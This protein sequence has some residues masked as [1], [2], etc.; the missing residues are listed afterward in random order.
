[1]LK[2]TNISQ[3]MIVK[4]EEQNI[5]R[6]LSWGKELMTE[7]IVVD[8]GSVDHTVEIAEQMG[9]KVF[10]LEWKGDFSEAK[11]F[12]IGQAAGDWIVFLDADEYL[13]EEDTKRL[14]ETLADL[15]ERPSEKD[16]TPDIIR[17]AILNL[18]DEGRIFS[19]AVQDRVFRNNGRIYYRNRIHEVLEQCD[20]RELR[21][22][23]KEKEISICH[24]GYARSVYEHTNKLER[25]IRILKSLLLEEPDNY[26]F[27]AY[28]GDSLMSAGR[29]ERAE[30]AYRKATAPGAVRQLDE[31]RRNLAFYG[32]MKIICMDDRE[33]GEEQL[34]QLYGEFTAIG[35]KNP[36]L[37]CQ[38]GQW[39]MDHGKLEEGIF[40]LEKALAAVENYN[41]D[42]PVFMT[43]QLTGVCLVLMNA[44]Y[45]LGK[46]QEAV[47][48]GVLVLRLDRYQ[49]EALSRLLLL[50]M[51]EPDEMEN[52]AG[53]YGFLN[54]LYDFRQERDRLFVLRAAE[55][56]QFTALGR[57][58]RR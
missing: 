56:N 37:E 34:K 32:L 21:I 22:L 8:T 12:A 41:S 20:G 29:M 58:L 26:E 28:L 25:N 39:M 53:T 48:Y 46:K 43:G 13:K 55:R 50:L 19:T 40:W 11:N 16:G 3:C 27:W 36:D 51:G 54:K 49:K 38:L 9:A 1:M 33:G 52:A 31:V 18:N 57:L 44:N 45:L 24:T 47:K 23:H 30:E 6:A 17:C 15:E 10:R 5:R 4:D 42:A 7:Q 35:G 14:Q 2:G